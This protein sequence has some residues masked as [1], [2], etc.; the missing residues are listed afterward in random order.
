MRPLII[1]LSLSLLPGRAAQRA[2]VQAPART[3][4]AAAPRPRPH[5][6]SAA[7]ASPPSRHQH[8][9]VP[10]VASHRPTRHAPPPS[11]RRAAPSPPPKPPRSPRRGNRR[12]RNTPHRLRRLV[13]ARPPAP[14]GGISPAPNPEKNPALAQAAPCSE[15][16]VRVELPDGK[17]HAV[18]I[19][20]EGNLWE[21]SGGREIAGDRGAGGVSRGSPRARRGRR[22]TCREVG[23]FGVGGAECPGAGA[24]SRRRRRWR[25]RSNKERHAAA[26]GARLRPEGR[27]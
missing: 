20:R 2:L 17:D 4:C 13:S 14:P 12:R 21:R 25:R 5:H 23:Y 9:E 1:H 27:G 7:L 3:E 19:L 26:G 11:A 8:R 10:L 15:G 6:L 18:E 16:L 24:S 22:E